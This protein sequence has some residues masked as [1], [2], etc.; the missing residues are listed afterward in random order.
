MIIDLLLKEKLSDKDFLIKSKNVLGFSLVE[1]V[2][3]TAI[4]LT[5]VVG[6]VSIIGDSIHKLYYAKDEIIAINLAQEAIEVVRQIRDSNMINGDTWDTGFTF[7]S[8]VVDVL[9]DPALIYCNGC[10][11]KVY[12]SSADG[13]YRQGAVF[14]PTQFSRIVTIDTIGPGVDERN[15]TAT[16]TWTTG[17]DGGTISVS[18][19]IFKLPR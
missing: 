3:A 17:G 2:V 12:Y 7:S 10:D 1:T 15:I 18:E 4:V 9:D 14:T 16:V 6:P 13:L 5:A 8:Y 11:Q 19:N